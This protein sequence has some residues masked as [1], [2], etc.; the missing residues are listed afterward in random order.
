VEQTIL[1]RLSKP[2]ESLL[3]LAML[4]IRD[5]NQWIVKE[6]AFRLCLTYVMFIPTFAAVAVVPLK[7]G[8]LLN[9][10][11]VVYV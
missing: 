5:N 1:G 3:S 4:C 11:H 2:I 7:S 6:D 10:D 9:I 8:D